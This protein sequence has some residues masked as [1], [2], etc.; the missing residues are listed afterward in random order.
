HLKI[1]TDN[2]FRTG[3]GRLTL[4]IGWQ[5]NLRREFGEAD[6][7]EE[8][9]LFFDLSTLSYNTALHFDDRNGWNTSV[10]LNGMVQDNNNRG[11]EVLIPEYGLFDIGGFVYAKKIRGRA[12]F[13]G[14]ARYDYRSLTAREF[15][16]GG[17][18]RFARLNR[19]FYNLS[20]S[21][22]VSYSVTDNFILKANLAR[23]FRAPSMPE[24]SSNGTH[25]GTNRY[26][27]G[28]KDLKSEISLQTDA[29]MEVNSEHVL[30]NAALFLNRINNFIYFRK[31]AGAGSQDSLVEVDGE[32]IP[33][34]RFDQQAASLYG[35]EV[36]VDIHPHPLDWLHWEN[37]FSYVRGLF[38]DETAGT[39]N[40]PYIPAARWTSE[41]RGEF[42]PDGRTFRN[43]RV[44][45]ELQHTFSQD[46]PFTAYGTET[47]TAGYTLLNAGLSSHIMKHN[48]PLFSVYFNATNLTDAAYQNHLSRLKYA[49]ENPV[50]GR[51]GVFNMGRNFS[52]RLNIPFSF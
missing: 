22:G 31:L 17:D 42:L 44:H 24:L 1:I 29:G 40:V 6:T 33:A 50:T 46:H 38:R 51:Q 13:S 11:A 25:E 36:L 45:M 23:G 14:G 10:G 16:E 19:S 2:S 28:N 7:P 48:R 52:L 26:E 30:I 47:A 8:E 9:S 4:N 5:Q 18:T 41:L 39:R 12:T 27:Y 3:N 15:R 35:G 37:T 34:F 49:A 21:A 43:L 32:F 20:G